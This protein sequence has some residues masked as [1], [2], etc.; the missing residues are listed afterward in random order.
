MATSS[1]VD[2]DDLELL[3]RR[4]CHGILGDIGRILAVAFFIQLNF[5]TAFTLG[6]FFEI[7]GVYTELLNRPRAEGIARRDEERKIVLEKEESQFRQVGGFADS[8]DSHNGNYVWPRRRGKWVQGGW[9]GDGG[10]GA[11]DVE[12]GCWG[13]DF[14]EG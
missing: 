3:R 4:I 6:E 11:K 5:T 9:R 1:G 2:E 12:G 8:V 10:Y 7:P 14:S 13:E